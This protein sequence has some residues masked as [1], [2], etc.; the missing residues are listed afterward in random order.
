[1]KK[2]NVFWGILLVTLGVIFILRNLDVFYFNFHSLFRLW[3]LI[4][5]FWGIAILP[6]KSFIKLILS[7]AAIL[8]AI[9][10]L[11]LYPSEEYSWFRWNSH[12][13]THEYNDEDAWKQQHL[14]DSYDSTLTMV[15]L[16]LDAA[17]GKFYIKNQT[18]ELYE[19]DNEGGFG[20]YSAI[21]TRDGNN[22]TIKVRQDQT[23]IRNRD[24]KNTVWLAL[25][26]EPVW[27]MN[28]EVGAAGLEMDIT[29]F[30][31]EKIDIKGGASSLELRL[32]ERSVQTKVN[33]D[34]GASS[35]ELKIPEASGCELH[36]STVLSSRD[37][38]G[39]EKI[40]T[41][42]YRTSNF[43]SATNQII[44]DVEAAVSSLSVIRY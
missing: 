7:G 17:A 32:G 28:I 19:I 40:S 39:F 14:T 6:V 26:P 15:R 8:I 20:S 30:K 25:N 13:H 16:D 43:S 5:V 23:H 41:G 27:E 38:E 33:I 4:F 44:I 34:A 10:I 1:M 3:P 29:P 37:L 35:I 31:V 18:Q 11:A 12:E 2:G 22:A 9:I 36:T 21:T 42:L 24:F